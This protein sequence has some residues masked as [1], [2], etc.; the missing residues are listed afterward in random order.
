M[1]IL[2]SHTHCKVAQA[3]TQANTQAKSLQRVCLSNRT[4][5]SETHDKQKSPSGN[6]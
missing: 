1:E 6:N 3:N 4:K 2:H 5:D